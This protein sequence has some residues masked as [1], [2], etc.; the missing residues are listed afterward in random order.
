MKTLSNFAGNSEGAKKGWSKKKQSF[1]LMPKGEYNE[2]HGLSRKE[3][4]VRGLG[5]GALSGT[6]VGGHLIPN[7]MNKNWKVLG[8]KRGALLG[9]GL[10]ATMGALGSQ[11]GY[12]KDRSNTLLGKIVRNKNDKRSRLDKIRGNN[13]LLLPR[14]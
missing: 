13:T 14:S 4:L 1:Y 2:R 5:S 10:G 3:S 11:L 6:L 7:I 12:R 9:L 8:S